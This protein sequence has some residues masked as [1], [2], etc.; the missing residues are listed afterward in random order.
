MTEYKYSQFA[1]TRWNSQWFQSKI[2]NFTLNVFG[3]ILSECG[4]FFQ[5]INLTS[6]KDTV[7]FLD[8]QYFELDYF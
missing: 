3:S 1:I 4:K 5:E 6:F 2:Q 8:L 7:R